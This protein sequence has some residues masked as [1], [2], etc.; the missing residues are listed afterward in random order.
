MCFFFIQL[1]KFN[2]QEKKNVLD[3]LKIKADLVTKLFNSIEGVKCNPVQ[4]AM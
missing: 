3:G 2:K 4:G 1:L